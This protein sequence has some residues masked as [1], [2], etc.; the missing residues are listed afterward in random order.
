[1]STANTLGA[2]LQYSEQER[3]NIALCKEYM[4]IAYDP[5]RASADAVAPL[6]TADSVFVGQST[7]PKA[8]T[9]PEYAAVHREV[10]DSVHDLKLLQYDWIVAKDNVVALRYTAAGSHTGQPWHGVAGD[11][12]KATWH[13]AMFFEVDQAQ[14]KISKVSATH[15]TAHRHTAR[16]APSDASTRSFVTVLADERRAC[17]CACVGC[18]AVRWRRSGTRR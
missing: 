3:N 5:K 9:V 4:A 1:M 16:H 11:G 18:G 10:M 14:G 2:S 13:A 12:A 6:C 15:S 17:C 8:R 7:F